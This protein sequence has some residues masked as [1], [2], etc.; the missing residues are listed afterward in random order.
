MGF[1]PSMGFRKGFSLGSSAR[2]VS[3]RRC[4]ST[5]LFFFFGS[6]CWPGFTSITPLNSHSVPYFRL[7]ITIPQTN[8]TYSNNCVPD[9]PC[10]PVSFF[11]FFLSLFTISC[12]VA[13]KGRTS[14]LIDVSPP[15]IYSNTVSPVSTFSLT[16]HVLP[17]LLTFCPSIGLIISFSVCPPVVP[18]SHH[19]TI[20]SHCSFTFG[21]LLVWFS[22]LPTIPCISSMH[23]SDLLCFDIYPIPAIGFYYTPHSAA[24]CRLGLMSFLIAVYISYHN[25]LSY[26]P[27]RSGPPGCRLCLL[28]PRTG[29]MMATG[30]EIVVHTTRVMCAS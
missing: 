25:Q 2:L 29:Q 4:K 11:S 16:E 7:Q 12:C 28:Y 15:S 22:D 27:T 5:S 20:F 6:P 8:R 3:I 18:P 21:V 24:T 23:I 10:I 9:L 14:T 19:L 17:M 30:Q 1:R 13:S 26:Q